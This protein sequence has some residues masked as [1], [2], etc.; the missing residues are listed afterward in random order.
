MERYLEG[1]HSGTGLRIG[2]AVSRFNEV[3]TTRLLEGAL[4]ALHD[5]GVVE[6]DVARVPG[7]FELPI[8][9]K[10][11]AQSGR[12]DA[13]V[14]LGAI[15]RGETQHHDYL[16]R[17]VTRGVGEAALTSMVPVTYGVL[18]TETVEQAMKRSDTRSD[19]R[20]HARAKTRSTTRPEVSSD[21]GRE[22]AMAAL[23][24]V[25][26]LKQLEKPR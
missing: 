26:L 6:I 13:V 24:M 11:M 2:I 8:A 9:V 20:S 19:T 16:A 25:H 4:A 12:Y 10:T 14:A 18:T 21:K 1:D 7:A 22:A 5:R 23:E 3:I 17:E 15:I